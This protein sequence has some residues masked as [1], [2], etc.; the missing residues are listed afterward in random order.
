MSGKSG[1]HHRIPEEDISF[2]V[3]EARKLR[4]R[5]DVERY[6]QFRV[7]RKPWLTLP[8][9]AKELDVSQGRISQLL[10]QGT[11]RHRKSPTRAGCKEVS[12]ADVYAY[13]PTP[14]KK[15]RTKTQ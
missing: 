6:T 5:A 8:E 11:F 2:C 9:A 12:A 13:T 7:A 1:M 15:T 3:A 10:S 4:A 14:S